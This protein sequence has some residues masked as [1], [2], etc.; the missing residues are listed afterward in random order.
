MKKT[1]LALMVAGL[2]A[3]ALVCVSCESTSVERVDSNTQVDLSGY[4]NDTDVRIVAESLVKDCTS[5]A[6]ITKFRQTYGRKPVMIVGSFK[7]ESDEHIDTSILALKIETALLNSGDVDFVASSSERGELRDER[8]DQQTWSSDETA[9]AYAEETGADVMMIG[10]VK[11]IIDSNN[12]TTTRSYFVY[13]QLID[14]ES[15]KKLWMGENSQIKKVIKR[16]AV[17]Y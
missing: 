3:I 17:R 4:W 8:N 12:G 5:S 6:A 16:S 7:N 13:A 15:N 11:T 1:G 10:T 9:K 2:A 14:V